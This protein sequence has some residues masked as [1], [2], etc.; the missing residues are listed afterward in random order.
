LSEEF[1]HPLFFIARPTFNYL[2]FRE[3]SCGSGIRFNHLGDGSLKFPSRLGVSNR[4][5]SER[6]FLS[7]VKFSGLG[8]TGLGFLSRLGFR[9]ALRSLGLLHGG[10][11]FQR[12]ESITPS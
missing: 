2:G 8:F 1:S 11:P 12:C 10:V 9:G 3:G 7:G 4:G 6:W 5:F